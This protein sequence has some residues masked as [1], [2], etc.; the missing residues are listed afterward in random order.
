MTETLLEQAKKIQQK[1]KLMKPV[2]TDE[3]IEVALAW[4][5]GDI[6]LYQIQKLYGFTANIG[7]CRLSLF[8]RTAY[9]KG[10]LKIV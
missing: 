1:R 5:S 2:V 7:Y 6:T 8:L 3:D 9:Q 4:M 10:L